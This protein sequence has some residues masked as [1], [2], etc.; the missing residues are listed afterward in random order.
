MQTP[1]TGV[2]YYEDGIPKIPHAAITIEDALLI[3][4]FINREKPLKLAYTWRPSNLMMHY[5]IM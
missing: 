3:E 5:H 4:R 2:M 1:H